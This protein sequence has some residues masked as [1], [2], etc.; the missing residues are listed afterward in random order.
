MIGVVFHERASD[1]AV[2]TF[3]YYEERVPGLGVSFL[4]DL[5]EAGR[6]IGEHPEASPLVDGEIRRKLFRRFPYSLLYV[7]EPGRIL[8]LAVAHHKRRPGYWRGLDT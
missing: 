4:L 1:E 7:V 8:V 2:E 6:L 3:R 5:E